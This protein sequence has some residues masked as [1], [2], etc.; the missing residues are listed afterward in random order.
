M[1]KQLKIVAEETKKTE[2]ILWKM[3]TINLPAPLTESEQYIGI[4]PG[5]THIGIA[6]YSPS[7][8]MD[9]I[10]LW[11]IEIER[12]ND[13]QIRAAYA[14]SIL[15]PTIGHRL[16]GKACIEGA[17][18]GNPYRQ[19]ELAEQRGVFL[20]WFMYYGIPAILIPPITIR[21]VVFGNGKVKAQEYW[22]TIPPNA[23]CALSC[24]YY[25]ER[26]KNG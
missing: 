23:A 3:M 17:A 11:E 12:S 5:T 20:A 2:N 6:V 13:A 18:Y 4:D 14:W 21:K 26:S 7:Q 9:T 25:L 16:G 1:D 8:R 24:L 10:N 22:D 19:V 15:Y